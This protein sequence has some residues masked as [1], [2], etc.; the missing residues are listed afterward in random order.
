MAV[1]WPGSAGWARPDSRRRCAGKSSAV[2]RQKPCL[3][4]VRQV[5]AALA[6]QAGVIA[7]RP[8]AL[9]RVGL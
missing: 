2:A 6:D 9:E 8:G 7:H 5:F 4:I 3:R 1:T